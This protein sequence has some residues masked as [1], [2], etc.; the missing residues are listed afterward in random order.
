MFKYINKISIQY[1]L[2]YNKYS[3]NGFCF[4]LKASLNIFSYRE[5]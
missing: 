3:L 4:Y 1:L 2:C 5:N